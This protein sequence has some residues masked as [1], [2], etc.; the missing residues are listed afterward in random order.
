MKEITSLRKYDGIC[1]LTAT[2]TLSIK[3]NV[4]ACINLK[5]VAENFLGSSYVDAMEVTLLEKTYFV[6]IDK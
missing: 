1:E 6:P 2:K 3:E 4:T 5:E